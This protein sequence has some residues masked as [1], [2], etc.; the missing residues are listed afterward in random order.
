MPSEYKEQTIAYK[1]TPL[2]EEPKHMKKKPKKKVKK[3]NHKH[4]YV[5]CYFS[6]NTYVYINGQKI[7]VY[8]PG[9]YCSVCGRIDN[10]SWKTV[11]A[12]NANPDWPIFKKDLVSF[13]V[14]KDKYV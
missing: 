4:I 2:P 13:L 10:I 5:P 3:A 14:D 7:E 11:P 8:N 1:Y 6:S 12:K 9:T